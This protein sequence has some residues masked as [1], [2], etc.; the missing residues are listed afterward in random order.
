MSQLSLTPVTPTEEPASTALTPQHVI[1]TDTVLARFPIHTLAKRGQMEIHIIVKNAH[2]QVECSWQVCPNP[3]FGAPRQLAYKL[4]TLVINKKLDELGRPLPKVIRLGSLREIGHQLGFSIGQAVTD[5]RKA[6]HQNAGTYIIATL[7]YSAT[8][9]TERTLEAGF[10]RYSVVFTGQRLPDGTTADAVYLVL[11]EPYWEVLNNAPTR[12]LDYDYL[13]ALTP[14]A[15]RCYEIISY[16]LFGA[17]KYGHPH[18]KQLYSEYCTFAAQ[19]RYPDYTHVKKQM[20]KI[21]KPHVA[22][23]YLTSVRYERTPDA[24]GL[25]DWMMF[26]VPGPKA[27]AEY[28]AFNPRSRRRA[29]RPTPVPQAAAHL[30]MEP[31]AAAP[32]P[33]VNEAQRTSAHELVQYF[34]ERFHGASTVVPTTAKALA[35]AQDLITR[36]GVNQA[37][38]V[39]DF[40]V[41]AANETDYQPQTFS[42]IVQYTARA[43]ADYE[44]AQ[45][46]R[47]AEARA[48]DERR[49]AQAD[50]ERHAQY[51]AYRAERLA[52]LR[53]SMPPDVLA[54]IEE[55]AAAQFEREHTSA[56]G[57]EVLRRAAL[58]HAVAAY[59][60]IPSFAAW[61]PAQEPC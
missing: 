41:T 33:V 44:K 50:D 5:L 42:G 45:Q 48:Q 3:A 51:E 18:A 31:A 2:G 10:T 28:A 58:D 59:G 6:A 29:E 14:A 22:S 7:H 39:V 34:H 8:D 12:P 37:R 40:S 9:G 30:D 56:F 4:D 32:T 43:L 60:Q 27:H 46:R 16:K 19:P 57:R 53:A 24:D 36:Y 21:H 38:H 54:A 47:A 17:L 20:Y 26:Y 15:Q 61:H 52:Q 1:R 49:R 11:N 55:A 23:A 13:K 25:P 35:Q